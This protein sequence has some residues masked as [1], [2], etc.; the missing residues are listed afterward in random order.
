MNRRI[1]VRDQIV[2]GL[3]P[4]C[5]GI[6]VDLAVEIGLRQ[7]T[8][9]RSELNGIEG[10]IFERCLQ[11]R[12]RRAAQIVNGELA[13]EASTQ[14]MRMEVAH[15]RIASGKLILRAEILHRAPEAGRVD[16]DT[17]AAHLAGKRNRLQRR[18]IGVSLIGQ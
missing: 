18:T 15:F 10:N 14:Q 13:I 1:G 7:R 2:Q 12:L 3:G 4:G 8:V 6:G 5:V 17:A 16:C 11:F 9:S